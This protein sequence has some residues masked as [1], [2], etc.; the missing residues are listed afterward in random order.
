LAHDFLN[1]PLASNEVSERIA[2]S[3]PW[4]IPGAVRIQS[5]VD[6][7]FTR[8]RRFRLAEEMLRFIGIRGCRHTGAVVQDV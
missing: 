5:L 3:F 2:S 8:F 1:P 6:D 7:P 4:E